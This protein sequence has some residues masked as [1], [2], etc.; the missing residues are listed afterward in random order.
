MPYSADFARDIRSAPRTL[1]NKLGRL[2]IS[3]GISVIR[4]SQ[5]TGATRQTV[6]NWFRGGPVLAAYKPYVEA[7]VGILQSSRSEDEAWRKICKTFK[8]S[9]VQNT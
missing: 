8:I 2:A 5:A 7:L 1:G 6:Y 3:T 9:P 4:I